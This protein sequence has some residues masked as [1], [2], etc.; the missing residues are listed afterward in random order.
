M[1]RGENMFSREYKGKWRFGKRYKDPLTDKWRTVTVPA[2]R[3]TR[4]T[5]NEAQVALD[6]MIR[7]K[8]ASITGEHNKYRQMTLGELYSTYWNEKKDSWRLNSRRTYR[9]S[10]KIFFQHFDQEAKLSNLTSLMLTNHFDNMISE[11]QKK[12]KN[13]SYKGSCNI[14]SIS[15]LKVYYARISMMFN[16]AVR[17]QFIKESPFKD[18]HIAWP[19]E[20]HRSLIE[21]KYLDEDEL[22]ILL[23]YFRKVQ[24][25]FADMFEWQYLTGM[26]F[27]EA[28]SLYLKDIDLKEML[29]HVNGTLLYDNG[30]KQ[31]YIKQ[32]VPKTDSSFREIALSDRAI[33][34][35]QQHAKGK[36]KND[37]LF[38][39]KDGCPYSVQHANNCLNSFRKKYDFGKIITTH[40]FRHTHVSKLAEL[41]VPLYVIQHNVGHSNSKITRDVYLH[42]TKKAQQEL[43]NKL[44]KM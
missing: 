25:D 5:R 37:F 8:L 18:V 27:G 41:G 10:Y 13:K 17:K 14:R 31:N 3:N 20:N 11:V 19:K 24:P 2:E 44:N 23:N 16:Y 9:N 21:Q 22:K 28:A 33:E 6:K 32:D 7:E 36:K 43:R 38:T 15:G 1:R 4:H 26:R 12:Q 30:P 39:D 40:T 29:V 35:Y 42:V 34:I